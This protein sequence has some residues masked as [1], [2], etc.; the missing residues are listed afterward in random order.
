M[1]IC[2]WSYFSVGYYWIIIFYNFL[3]TTWRITDVYLVFLNGKNYYVAWKHL[4]IA[5][6]FLKVS[7]V[8]IKIHVSE[9]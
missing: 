7:H 3:N 4:F 5:Q 6:L 9:K 8:V 1:L 2:I